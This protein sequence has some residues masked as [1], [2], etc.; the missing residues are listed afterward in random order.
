MKIGIIGGGIIGRLCAWY[1]CQQHQV[2]I[3]DQGPID[4]K[5]SCSYAAAAMLAPYAEV[6]TLGQQYYQLALE[7]LALWPKL[8]AE[9]NAEINYQQQGSIICSRDE[10]ELARFIQ[11]IHH[12]LGN[13]TDIMPLAS[14]DLLKLEPELTQVTQACWLK[15]EAY[16]DNQALLPALASRLLQRG[17]TWHENS[18]VTQ[19][20]QTGIAVANVHYQFDHY[21]DCRGLGSTIAGL[22]A[23]RGELIQLHA[24]NVK[25]TRPIRLKHPSY[26]LYIVPRPQQRYLIGA[27][28][29]EA[30][31]YSPISVQSTL[32]LLSAAYSIHPGFIDAR[33]ERTVTQCRPAFNSNLPK[34][35]H[36]GNISYLNGFHRHGYLLGPIMAQKLVEEIT[37][38]SYA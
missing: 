13:S 33:I 8:I 23:V 16:V 12:H 9:I 26:P 18:R 2:T 36:D 19:L 22:R 5:Q 37:C 35:I 10:G 24:P 14:H 28:E 4:D 21:I 29:I 3:F 7:S 1:L 27:T 15:S 30:C 6:E 20:N 11:H 38:Q 17:V 25:L 32:E 31:D 34:I